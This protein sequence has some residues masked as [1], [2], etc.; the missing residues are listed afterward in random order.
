[1]PDLNG[2]LV[3]FDETGTLAFYDLS[4]GKTTR[5]FC[6]E[7]SPFG[8]P[9]SGGYRIIHNPRRREV[10]FLCY[11]AKTSVL[12]FDD[13]TLQLKGHINADE[14]SLSAMLLLDDHLAVGFCHLA[15]R[16]YLINLDQSK[17]VGAM[18]ADYSVRSAE[19]FGDLYA[20]LSYSSGY[21]NVYDR[22][23]SSTPIARFFVGKGL[24]QSMTSNGDEL[25]VMTS[26][27]LL[28]LRR[29]QPGGGNQGP[30]GNGA[31]GGPQVEHVDIRLGRGQ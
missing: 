16:A 6:L 8:K 1:M 9:G 29:V 19:K 17:V 18:A 3:V 21:L 28:R 13:R 7:D 2:L 30:P 10:Y 4:S 24:S 20:T 22:L 31:D 14:E 23:P 27:G 5:F 15:P 25:L 26:K 11:F 12:V